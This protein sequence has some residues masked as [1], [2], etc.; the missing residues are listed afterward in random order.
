METRHNHSA[1]LNHA[2]KCKANHHASSVLLHFAFHS[3]KNSI[4]VW[5]SDLLELSNPARCDSSGK[6]LIVSTLEG[7]RNDIQFLFT[8]NWQWTMMSVGGLVWSVFYLPSMSKK[9]RWLFLLVSKRRLWHISMQIISW[10]NQSR[11]GTH[12]LYICQQ[13][14]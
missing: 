8:S 14:R 2:C 5:K 1:L 6:D 7:H 10:P 4:H 13:Q 12:N 3:V 11:K 9:T